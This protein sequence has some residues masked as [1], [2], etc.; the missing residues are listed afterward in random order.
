MPPG[1]RARRVRFL[2]PRASKPEA[3]GRAS[4]PPARALGCSRPGGRGGPGATVSRGGRRRG[5]DGKGAPAPG[6]ESRGAEAKAAQPSC[7]REPG[8]RRSKARRTSER[9]LAR[10][11]QDGR[12]VKALDL[13][14][15]GHMSAWVRTPLLVDAFSL[16][17]KSLIIINFL[18]CQC[19]QAPHTLGSRF[20]PSGREERHPTG[21]G[22]AP[23]GPGG[24]GARAGGARAAA[25]LPARASPAQEGSRAGRGRALLPRCGPRAARGPGGRS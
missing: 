22:S 12:V 11:H 1:A 17:F 14:S 2:R 21:R 10:L 5:P 23:P 6:R 7:G 25:S 8:G 18:K 20:P 4:G 19:H 13:R 24:G 16:S 9:N 3:P 15:N